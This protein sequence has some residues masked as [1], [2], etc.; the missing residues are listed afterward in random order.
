MPVSKLFANLLPGHPDTQHDQTDPVDQPPEPKARPRAT[1][2]RDKFRIHGR[3]PTYSGPYDVGT[4]DLEL[5]VRDPRTF[6]DITRHKIHVLA[7]ETVLV[8]IYYPAKADT[9][10]NCRHQRHKHPSNQRQRW[11]PESRLKMSQAYARYGSLP[12]FVLVP[13]LMATT[14]TTKLPAQEQARM[15]DRWPSLPIDPRLKEQDSGESPTQRL[16]EPVFP[17]IM[18][19]HGMGGNRRTSS[20]ICGELAS[21]GFVVCALEHRDGSGSYSLIKHAP[22]GLSSRQE[23]EKEGGREHSK[24]KPTTANDEIKFVF[25]RQDKHDS[26]PGHEVDSELRHAQIRMREAE[27]A[28]AYELIK[29]LND[30]RGDDVAKNNLRSTAG[31]SGDQMDWSSWR[32]KVHTDKV[33][34]MGHSFGAVTT[35]RVLRNSKLFPQMTQG[36]IYD[37]WGAPVIPRFEVDDFFVHRPLLGMNSEAFTNWPRNF[38]VAK[39]IVQ[40]SL[41]SCNRAWLMTVRGTIHVSQTDFCL[42]YPHLSR[43]AVKA[44]IDPLRAI[45]LN[46]EA[47]LEFLSRVLD[48]G[49]QPF[50]GSMK[51][52]TFLDQT[53]LP[54]LPDPG[55]SGAKYTAVRPR[56]TEKVHKKHYT[57]RG[58]KQSWSRLGEDVNTDVW[59]HMAPSAETSQIHARRSG[60]DLPS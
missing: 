29:L 1:T 24:T 8:S 31:A 39:N 32:S 33:T 18:F 30:G 40:E 35:V 2:Y 34:M 3:L 26:T 11:L 14:W 16:S 44:R 15:A 41:N 17:L 52:T 19:S 55:E 10:L 28:E 56:L 58:R 21:Y 45:D 53:V 13:F 4:V 51:K 43:F 23:L 5:P 9:E 60:N 50:R 36:I 47:S 6:S 57:D 27:I 59:L 12:D 7:L 46:V 37:I 25:P 42:M 38:E 48:L 20:T 54:E 49:E 22:S